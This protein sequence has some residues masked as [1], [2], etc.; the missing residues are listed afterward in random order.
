MGDGKVLTGW[1]ECGVAVNKLPKMVFKLMKRDNVFAPLGGAS[2][3]GIYVSDF[4]LSF[5]DNDTDIGIFTYF[6]P[7]KFGKGQLFVNGYNVGRYWPSAGPEV[8]F[9]QF[10]NTQI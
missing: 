10:Q 4:E 2:A 1:F 5:P 6:D 7:A 9:Q 3:P 8:L